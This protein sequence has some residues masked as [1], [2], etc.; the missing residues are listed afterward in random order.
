[1]G[2]LIWE[3]GR[4]HAFLIV[5][6]FFSVD[7]L[8]NRLGLQLSSNEDAAYRATCVCKAGTLV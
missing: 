6:P 8:A 2:E 4:C 7:F 3:K 5:R 1:M